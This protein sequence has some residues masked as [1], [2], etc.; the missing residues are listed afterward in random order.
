MPYIRPLSLTD[1]QTSLRPCRSFLIASS[2]SLLSPR[3]SL[4]SPYLF[5]A[6]SFLFVRH[7]IRQKVMVKLFHR[8]SICHDENVQLFMTKTG[9]SNNHYVQKIHCRQF[10]RPSVRPFVRPS[11]CPSVRRSVRQFVRPSRRSVR[12]VLST[13]TLRVNWTEREIPN[14]LA[15]R[16][17]SNQSNQLSDFRFSFPIEIDAGT[18]KEKEGDT[19]ISY[20][21]SQFFLHHSIRTI[22]CRRQRARDHSFFF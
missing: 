2:L 11:V 16:S 19:Y 7:V 3:R 4:F 13:V 15:F 21:S 22:L 5:V 18:A 9:M 20:V 12:L 6:P 8:S 17:L 10:V 14:R 1:E